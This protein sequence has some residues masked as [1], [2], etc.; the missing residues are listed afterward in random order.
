[1]AGGLLNVVAI[2][3]Y[4]YIIPIES[5]SIVFDKSNLIYFQQQV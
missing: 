4:L 2:G 1:M 5:K 3:F